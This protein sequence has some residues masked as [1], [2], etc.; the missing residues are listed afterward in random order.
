MS[1]QGQ[2]LF[3]LLPALY[4]LKD[5]ALNYLSPSDLAELQALQNKKAPLDPTD[6]LRLTQLSRGPLESLLMLIEE[7]FAVIEEDLEQLYDDQFI[8]TCAPWVIPYIG[9]LIGYQLVNGVAPMVA[10]PRAEVADTISMRRRKGTILVLE[11]LARDVTG[12]GAHAVESFRVLATTQY[13]KHIRPHNYSAPNVRSWKTAEYLDTSFDRTAHTV[14]THRIAAGRGRYNIQNIAIFLWSL[15]AYSLTE[16]PVTAVDSSGQ[17][18]RLNPLGTDMC[19]FNRPVSQGPE[20]RAAAQPVNVPAPLSRR[21]LCGDI[22]SGVG[23]TYYGEGKSLTLRFNNALLNP[24]QIQVCDLSG[25]DGSWANVPAAGSPY[26]VGVDPELGRIALAIPLDPAPAAGSVTQRLLA[27]YCYGFNCDIGGGEYSRSDNF[28]VPAANAALPFP[29]TSSTPRYSTLPDALTFAAANLDGNGQIAVEIADSGVYALTASPALQINVPAGA[30]IE[31]RGAEGRRPTLVV[32][33]EILVTG[34]ANSAFSLNG[35]L[36]AYEPPSGATNP[37]ALLHVPSGGTNELGELTL[38][39]CTIVPGWARTTSGAPQPAY[40]GLPTVLAE[41]PGLNIAITNSIVGGLWVDLETSCS[42]SGCIVDACDPANVAYANT[43][44][45]N[46]GGALTLQYC[47]VVGKVHATLFSMVS[48]SIVWATSA[49][50]DRRQQG[51]VR[52][53]YLPPGSIVPRQFECVEEGE[54]IP[55]PLFYSLRYGDPGYGKLWP[56]TDDSI[57]KG[58]ENGGEMGAFN[59]VLAA[60]READLRAR[61]QEYLPAGLEFGIFYQN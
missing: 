30:T 9:D 37:A 22:Q 60:L 44:G 40:S 23:A 20:I 53:T 7:Q 10:S 1:A 50:A 54:G 33:G 12:W 32:G 27:S 48:D 35:L 19:L 25:P 14:D 49:V 51:C 18:F 24:Y 17:L 4:R 58:A 57:R 52:F 6:Q 56:S 39:D 61:V 28:T 31:L 43:D 13:M 45:K 41:S 16:T 21:V 29:D 11:Q 59:S 47:T 55:R 34:S 46:G 26:A 3:D 2:K 8:E 36:I 42:L 38:T 5:G 15:N